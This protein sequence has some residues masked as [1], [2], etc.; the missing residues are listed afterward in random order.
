MEKL[1]TSIL[2]GIL[3]VYEEN[4][5]DCTRILV[6]D[7][8]NF[9]LTYK[10][11]TVIK[12]LANYYMINL[13]ESK[14]I[15]SKFIASKNLVPLA[16]DQNNIFIPIKTRIPRFKNDRAFGYINLQS[17][18]QLIDRGDYTEL[19]LK[20]GESINCMAKKNTIKKHISH[21]NIIKNCFIKRTMRLYDD[22]PKY[23]SLTP[24]SREDIEL[25]IY[26]ISDLTNNYLI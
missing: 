2:I 13:K 8:E 24:A 26:M 25:L 9:I 11:T 3:P 15:Y 16:F 1:Y 17:I 22:S 5:G 6:K 19:K 23:N 7:G 4:I 20:N 12:R 18:Q 10:I 21:G 14:K